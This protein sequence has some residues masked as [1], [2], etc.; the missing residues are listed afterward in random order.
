MKKIFAV[1]FYNAL[2]GSPIALKQV[3]ADNWI[4]AFDKAKKRKNKKFNGETDLGKSKEIVLNQDWY[5]SVKKK[6][7]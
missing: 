7:K 4:S 5:F 6:K 2:D 3:I 1:A